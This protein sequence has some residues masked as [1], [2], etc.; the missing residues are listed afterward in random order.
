MR[1]AMICLGAVA[2]CLVAAV[3]RPWSVADWWTSTAERDRALA[4]RHRD[5]AALM[6]ARTRSLEK[7][8]GIA[9]DSDIRKL[10]LEQQRARDKMLESYA[11]AASAAGS[12]ASVM[13]GMLCCAAAGCAVLALML[14]KER[15]ARRR[16][17]TRMLAAGRALKLIGGI[18]ERSI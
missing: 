17:E 14:R 11:A 13:G 16:A 5:Q 12:R 2:L 8:A 15:T 10:F 7:T 1:S 9:A 6:D 4:D 3:A 18:H